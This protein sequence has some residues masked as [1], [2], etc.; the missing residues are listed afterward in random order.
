MKV[1]QGN[2]GPTVPDSGGGGEWD[3][4][5]PGPCVR[6]SWTSKGLGMIPLVPALLGYQGAPHNSVSPSA[7]AS[8]LWG[9]SC[10]LHSCL[11]HCGSS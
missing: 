2:K 4:G 3:P 5:I 6:S 9:L 11:K 10:L 1:T 7:A 8:E